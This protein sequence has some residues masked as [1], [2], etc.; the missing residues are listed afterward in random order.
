M[1]IELPSIIESI[2]EELFSAT[3]LKASPTERNRRVQALEVQ[4]LI[5][6]QGLKEVK[7][8]LFGK[9]TNLLI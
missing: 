6:Q 5:C 7:H 1:F 3:A 4:L 8:R 9:L 2:N